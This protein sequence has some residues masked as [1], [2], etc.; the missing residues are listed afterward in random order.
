MAKQESKTRN[1]LV[2]FRAVGPGVAGLE[3]G[4]T[5][6]LID[7]DETDALVRAGLLERI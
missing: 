5:G 2:T 7:N 6:E 1:D 3:A 4:Q